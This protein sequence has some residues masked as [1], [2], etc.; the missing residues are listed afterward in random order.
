MFESL[1]ASPLFKGLEIED[2]NSLINNSSH[3]IKQF[4]NKEV[5]AY[6]GEKVEKAMILLEGRLQ[7]EMIDFAGNSLK[8]EEMEPPQM[9]AAAFLYGPQS[10]FPVNLSAISDGKML[11]IFKNDFTQLLAA[12]QRVLNNY[13]NIVSGKAQFLSRKI[14]FLSFKTIKEKIAYYLLQNFKP[15]NQVVIIN[16]SQKGLAEMLGVARPSLART[17]SEMESDQLIKWER[18]QVEIVDLKSL[19]AILGR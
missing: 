18:N 2:I 14:T 19:Q 8:I 13:L 7:G 16:Q 6:A 10:A 11:V 1:K 3:Q 17:I 5:L 9:V 12:D 4:S 15:N